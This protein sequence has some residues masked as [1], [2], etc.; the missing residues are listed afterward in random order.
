MGYGLDDQGIGVRFPAGA[1]D[2]L[3]SITSRPALG[4]TKPPT[5]WAPEVA[6]P[7]EKRQER[8]GDHSPPTSPE[9]NNGE[10]IP[11]LPHTSHIVQLN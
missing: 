2:S 1:R 7:G 5:Q 3:F 10:A 9:V 4:P 8:E 11:P 6:S